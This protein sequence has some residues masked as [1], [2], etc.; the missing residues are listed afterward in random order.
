[1][2]QWFGALEYVPKELRSDE[3]CLEAVRRNKEAIKY[4]SVQTIDYWIESVEKKS[5][6]RAG[7]AEGRGVKKEE[8]MK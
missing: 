3:I 8:R 4:V 6:H 1:V 2:K 7:A 5:N